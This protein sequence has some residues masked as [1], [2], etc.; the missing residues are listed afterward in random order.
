LA[1][2][3]GWQFLAPEPAKDTRLAE[4]C[5]ISLVY[6]IP[7]DIRKHLEKSPLKRHPAALHVID[8][9]GVPVDTLEPKSKRVGTPAIP[10]T[11]VNL[12]N[13]FPLDRPFERWKGK[14][15]VLEAKSRSCDLNP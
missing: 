3:A 6:T 14:S 11:S 9:D 12:P 5:T 2:S 1:R 4:E 15:F 13:L 10:Q 7:I 8:A